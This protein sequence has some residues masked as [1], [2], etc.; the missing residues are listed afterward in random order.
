MASEPGS[1][2]CTLGDLGAVSG[3]KGKSKQRGKVGRE[4]L[5]RKRGDLGD[6]GLPYQFQNISVKAS[7]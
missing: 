3:G 2:G 1:N 6:G 4:N 5:E 7:F